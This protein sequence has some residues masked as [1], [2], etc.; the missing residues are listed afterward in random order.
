MNSGFYHSNLKNIIQENPELEEYLNEAVSRI[1]K[2]KE[3]INLFKNHHI[4]Q[5]LSKKVFRNDRYINIARK[6]AQESIVL[7]KNEN[8]ILP[9]KNNN[10]KIGLIG[11]FIDDKDTPLGC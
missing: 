11:P 9:I 4:D 7:L 1:I 8:K 6:A 5:N 10:I 2:L 3:K